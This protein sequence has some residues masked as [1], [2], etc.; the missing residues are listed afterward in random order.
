[1]PTY[2]YRCSACGAQYEK[3][4]GFDAA[5]AHA[6]EQCGEG[7]AKRMISVPAIVFKGSGFYA[8]D[9][10]GRDEDTAMEGA[11]AAAVKKAESPST[12][13]SEAPAPAPGHGH[14]HGPGGHTH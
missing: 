5:T 8:T 14:S 4:E 11:A 10:R 12:G 3:R 1:M 6:C 7:E 13:G 2:D 9:S